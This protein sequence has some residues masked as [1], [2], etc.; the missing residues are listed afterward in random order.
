[1]TLTVEASSPWDSAHSGTMLCRVAR[2]AEMRRTPVP[3]VSSTLRW[4]ASTAHRRFGRS[5]PSAADGRATPGRCGSV[6]L[7]SPPARLMHAANANVAPMENC[8]TRSAPTNGPMNDPIRNVP[9][10]EESARARK[11]GAIA[12]DR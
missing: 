12:S 9:P 8:S 7:S 1:M 10:S 2:A 5:G 6:R 4:L 11:C 3:S